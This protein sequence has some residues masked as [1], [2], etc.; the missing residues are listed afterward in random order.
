[1]SGYDAIKFYNAIKLH[2][3]DE[4][5]NAITYNYNT[6]IKFIPENQ[7]YSFQ[8][9]YKLYKDD[10]INFYVANFYNNPKSSVFD[11]CSIEADSTYKK[12]KKRNDS[13][14]YFFTE[15]VRMLLEEHSLNELLIV[16][17]TYPILM[18]KN[19]QEE[20]SVDTLLLL[21]SILQFFNDWDKKIKQDII[22][23]NFKMKTNKYRCFMN[24]DVEKYKRILKKEFL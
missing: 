14:A 15:D 9:L 13:L 7:L 23:K 2:F 1:M 5:Y 12:W 3:N 10:I 19:M 22:W 11:L 20:I 8:K 6:K 21:D 4:K 16:K 18:I 24:I 17:K